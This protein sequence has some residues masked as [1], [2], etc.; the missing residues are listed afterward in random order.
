MNKQ[1]GLVIRPFK[2]AHL[3]RHLDQELLHLM[4]YLTLVGQL[5]KLSG[6]DHRRWERY[7]AKYGSRA[8]QNAALQ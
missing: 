1:Q 4:H 3:T 7:L 8:L 6:L 2:K 5:D